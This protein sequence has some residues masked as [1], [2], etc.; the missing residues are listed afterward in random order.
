MFTGNRHRLYSQMEDESMLVLFSGEAPRKLSDQF[1]D[2]FP[3][4]NFYYLTGLGEMGCAFVYIK[5]SVATREILYTPAADPVMEM[6]A[7][8]PPASEALRAVSGIEA[9]EPI[10]CLDRMLGSAVN[11]YRVKT[12]YLDMGAFD[13]LDAL[14]PG[15]SLAA[16]LRSKTAGVEIKN[17]AGKLEA[18]RAIKTEGEIA[19][20]QKAID[21]TAEAFTAMMQTVRPGMNEHELDALFRYKVRMGGGEEGFQVVA[22]GSN[23]LTLHYMRNNTAIGEDDLVLADCGAIWNHYY[24]DITRTFPASGR[25]TPRQKE[26]YNIVLEAQKKAIACVRPGVTV[27]EISDTARDSIAKDC[28]ALG[29]ID[30]ESEVGKR[31]VGGIGHFLGLECHDTTGYF[32]TKD[33][34]LEAGMV[35]TIE[36]G[37]YVAEENIGIRIE[38]DVLVEPNGCRVLSEALPK[39]AEAVEVLMQGQ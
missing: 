1:Y 3:D 11:M 2:F 5:S 19:Y 33:L 37:L 22:T 25:F 9:I 12:V 35:I 34:P 6:I 24:S 27:A 39:T 23:A 21:I 32:L 7:G 26:L 4:R 14:T 18:M 28:V 8:K 17:I 16:K 15:Q 29:L 13:R 36:P 30:D 31:W 10:N 38:D 20:M